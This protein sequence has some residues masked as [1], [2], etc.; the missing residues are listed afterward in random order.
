M[1]R[2]P[3]KTAEEIAAE[4]KAR[5]EREDWLYE[6]RNRPALESV[7][8]GIEEA[9]DYAATMATD[10][11]AADLY[12]ELS[13][14]MKFTQVGE[15]VWVSDCG[16]YWLE[17]RGSDAQPY[18]TAES[19]SDGSGS[20]APVSR[21]ALLQQVNKSLQAAIEVC[22]RHRS[23]EPGP[24]NDDPADYVY[25][26]GSDRDES[27]LCD[28]VGDCFS[29]KFQRKFLADVEAKICG[30]RMD[31]YDI[32]EVNHARTGRIATECLGMPLDAK[33]VC[34]ANM[35]QKLSRLAHKITYDSLQDLAGYAANLAAI[36]AAE[37]AAFGT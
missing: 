33:Q 21:R 36:M 18:W 35:A 19:I 28:Q 2:G 34:L 15:Q 8:K 13:D 32:P 11:Q 7:L 24:Y 9:K 22:R 25:R 27:R 29:V 1:T 31:D 4:Y 37:E 5:R 10:P 23:G 6:Q 17:Q 16:Y 12:Q 3:S 30:D 20:R 26:E 14:P